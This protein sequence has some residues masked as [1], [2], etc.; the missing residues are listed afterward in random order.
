M[1]I[2]IEN[3]RTMRDMMN[4]EIQYLLYKHMD[5]SL[6]TQAS[7]PFMFTQYSSITEQSYITP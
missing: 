4:E 6:V 2:F 1:Q 3:S 7:V 5:Q